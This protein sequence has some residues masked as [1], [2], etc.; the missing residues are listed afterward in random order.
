MPMDSITAQYLESL[1]KV[2]G[3]YSLAALSRAGLLNAYYSQ[4]IALYEVTNG[5][6]LA[7]GAAAGGLALTAGLPLVT[8]V[9]VGVALG[10]GYYQARE[11]AKNE[12][13]RSGFSQGF[14]MAI[15]NWNWDHAVNRFGRMRLSINKFDEKLN[16]IRVESYHDGLKRGFLAGRALPPDTR[17]AFVDKIR[18]AGGVRGPKQWS[19]NKEEARN[20]QI[21][22][23]IDLAT[24]AL[25]L[26]IIKPE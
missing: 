17:K 1:T 2:G 19:D 16:H 26:Q 18:E 11:E 22:Y 6:L 4:I 20:Q 9:G 25:R 5:G 8:M 15:L 10:S 7:G 21:S 24:A 23:V 12:N 13:F 14:V 3:L